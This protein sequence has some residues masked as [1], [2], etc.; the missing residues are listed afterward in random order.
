MSGKSMDSFRRQRHKASA[1]QQ[2]FL[3][4]RKFATAGCALFFAPFG[5]F[6]KMQSATFE[7]RKVCAH[8]LAG[9]YLAFWLAWAL[10]PLLATE[11][12]HHD[13]K[14]VCVH[15]PG[16]EHL[17]SAEYAP[18]DCPVCHAPPATAELFRHEMPTL[19][20][21][22]IICVPAFVPDRLAEAKSLGLAQPRAPPTSSC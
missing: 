12:H 3:P 22:E 2:P 4:K 9:T 10:H 15:A 17:H 19:G 1:G 16:E 5:G 8:L 11:H 20:A 7:Y 6:M 18:D 21:I 13:E 14:P